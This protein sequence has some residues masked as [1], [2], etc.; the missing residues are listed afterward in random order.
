MCSDQGTAVGGNDEADFSF[1]SPVYHAVE[2]W[3]DGLHL[4]AD[5]VA[6]T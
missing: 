5:V 4:N 1:R 2:E 6:V 3:M